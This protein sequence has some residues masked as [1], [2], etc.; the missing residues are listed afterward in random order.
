MCAALTIKLLALINDEH[1]ETNI[2]VTLRADTS[3]SFWYLHFIW[4]NA[5]FKYR[6]EIY[7]FNRIDYLVGT[8]EPKIEMDINWYTASVVARYKEKYNFYTRLP[9]SK[10]LKCILIII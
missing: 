9:V 4:I 10:L 8:T 6:R 2:P 3:D 7:L 5:P 1:N